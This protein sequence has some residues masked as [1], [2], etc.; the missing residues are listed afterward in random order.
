MT[1]FTLTVAPVGD[2]PPL[3]AQNPH[4]T[5][6]RAG[7]QRDEYSVGPNGRRLRGAKNA[8]NRPS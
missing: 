8:G 4:Q 6:R 7:R 3:R 1:V 5:P 2:G